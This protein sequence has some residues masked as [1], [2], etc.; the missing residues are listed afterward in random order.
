MVERELPSK[1]VL[2][3]GYVGDR[4]IR[5]LQNMNIN[6]APANAG[7]NG[8]ILNAQFNHTT[9]NTCPTATNPNAQ[10]KGWPDIN[11]LIPLGNN[12]YDSLQAKLTR[13]FAGASQ[14]GVAYTFSK[15]IDYEDNEEINFLLWPYPAYIDRNKALAGFDRTHNFEAYGVYELPFGRGKRYAQSGIGTCWLA[16]GRSTGS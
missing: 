15:A 3:M 10:C 13:R 14:I 1:F 6:P 12:Y 5:P 4:A 9:S 11:Q 2:D 7:Q 8:R 16:D